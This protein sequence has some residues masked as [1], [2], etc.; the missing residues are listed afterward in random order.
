MNQKIELKELICSGDEGDVERAVVLLEESV[1]KGD[2]EAMWMLGLC[3]EYGIGTEQNNE[4][5]KLLYHQSNEA[6][7]AVGVFLMLNGKRGSK[8]IQVVGL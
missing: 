2:D 8:K 1:G 3:C 7:N 6:G 5:A 4:R